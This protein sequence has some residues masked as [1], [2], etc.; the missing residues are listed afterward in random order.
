[1]TIRYLYQQITY[2]FTCFNHDINQEYFQKQKQKDDNSEHIRL[3]EPPG[4]VII[5]RD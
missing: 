1:M 4:V 5:D 2:L 3:T